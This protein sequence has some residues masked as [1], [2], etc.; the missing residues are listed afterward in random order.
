M[1]TCLIA[2]LAWY[3]IPDSI[4]NARFL[5]DR[6]KAVATRF[7]ARNQKLDEGNERKLRLKETLEAFKDPKGECLLTEVNTR[8]NSCDSA[9]I[10]GIMYF[11]CNVSFA[12][13][14][15]FVP[16]IISEIGAFTS[17]QSNGLS[18]PPYV[19]CFFFIIGMTFASDHFK[20]RGPFCAAAG[21]ISAIGFIV[22]ATT[23][24][25]GPRYFGV[26]LAVLIFASVALLLAWTSNIHATESKRAGGYTILATIGQC[27]PLL[28]T[29]M[30]PATEAPYYRKG[31]WIGAAF[32][33]LVFFLSIALSLWLRHENRKLDRI[34]N[35]EE[36]RERTTSD[37]KMEKSFRYIW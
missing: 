24:G 28:G 7:V 36:S 33:L 17:I 12:S 6:E 25:A 35:G 22:L 18:A 1:P 32:C 21:L 9:Y 23:E 13:L 20:M 10:P 2:I 19:L 11:S 34:E 3:Y 37:A 4:N 8:A 5:N 29:N 30:F 14:P 16:T 26:F 15:L 27:G 31:M